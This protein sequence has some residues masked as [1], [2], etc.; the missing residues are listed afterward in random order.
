M[1]HRR[2]RE[3]L[4]SDGAILN[5]SDSKSDYAKGEK[6]VVQSH[7]CDKAYKKVKASL[8]KQVGNIKFPRK[9]RGEAGEVRL[10]N[11]MVMGI[12]NYYQL[13]TDISIDCGDIGRTVNTVLKTG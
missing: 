10:F 8:T 2:K 6:Y 7:M 12:Q 4:T 11:S 5:F 9:G 3:L 13:A 1:F